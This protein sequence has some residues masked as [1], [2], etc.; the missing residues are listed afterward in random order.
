MV[1]EEDSMLACNALV[2]FEK[3]NFALRLAPKVAP[4]SAD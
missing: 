4:S 2:N 3:F 1:P